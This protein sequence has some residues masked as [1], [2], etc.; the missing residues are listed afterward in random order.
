MEHGATCAPRTPNGSGDVARLV[1]LG[2][3]NV[4]PWVALLIAGG[5]LAHDL[6]TELS[7]DRRMTYGAAARFSSIVLFFTFLLPIV[8]LGFKVKEICPKYFDIER[9]SRPSPRLSTC[10]LIDYGPWDGRSALGMPSG[11]ASTMMACLFGLVWLYRRRLRAHWNSSWASLN[12]WVNER[13]ALLI[14][15][16]LTFG[17][18]ASRVQ[19]GCHSP[20]QVF[21]GSLLGSAL[22]I[23][24][25]AFVVP[26]A[27]SIL[28][29]AGV[30]RRSLGGHENDSPGQNAHLLLS[31]QSESHRNL[32]PRRVASLYRVTPRAC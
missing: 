8:Y 7:R 1:S 10:S 22:G 11:H 21:V 31:S 3:S 6:A 17:V 14:V 26:G 12:P 29:L 24:N 25:G 19:L 27:V 28:T 32:D 2:F 9:C 4:G 13:L 16:P 20:L 23:I 30:T 15:G 5:A 18:L